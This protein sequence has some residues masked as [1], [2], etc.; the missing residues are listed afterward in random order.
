MVILVYIFV[1]G[2]L[3]KVSNK[4]TKFFTIILLAVVSIM[5]LSGCSDNAATAAREWLKTFGLDNVLLTNDEQEISESAV[6]VDAS[7][8]EPDSLET[9]VSDDTAD[10]EAIIATEAQEAAQTQT[11]KPDVY[12]MLLIGCDHRDTSW[13]GNSDV[14]MLLSINKSKQTISLI[15]FMRDIGVEIPDYGYGK[16]NSAFAKGGGELLKSTIESNF[17]ISINNYISTDFQGMANIIDVFDGVDIEVTAEE[18]SVTNDYITEIANLNGKDPTQYYITAAGMQHLNGIQAVSFMRDRYVGNS[19]FERTERQ[20]RVV[21]QLAEKIKTMNFEQ[22][23]KLASEAADQTWSHDLSSGQ[24]MQLAALLMECKNYTLVM[25][26]IPYD[27][28]Y[29]WGAENLD[30]IWADTISRLHNTLY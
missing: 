20:R 15:S 12:Q 16:L 1:K 21:Q 26:R 13:N 22:L 30:P 27:G 24:I 17:Q 5:L 4:S 25:D 2:G 14:V 9:S 7:Q 8:G 23:L 19:D 10:T 18:I 29:N 3:M 6:I 28:L 11:T